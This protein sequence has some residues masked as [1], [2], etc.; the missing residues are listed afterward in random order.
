MGKSPAEIIPTKE[1]SSREIK[2]IIS[3]IS[4][5]DNEAIK[6][7]LD[8]FCKA[9]DSALHSD[10][11][12]RALSPLFSSFEHMTKAYKFTQDQ[13]ANYKKIIARILLDRTDKE[14]TKRRNNFLLASA[15]LALGTLATVFLRSYTDQSA[16][17]KQ[18]MLAE[19]TLKGTF[20]VDPVAARDRF[21]IYSSF[22]CDTMQGLALKTIFDTG[23]ALQ[24]AG[25]IIALTKSCQKNPKTT[26]LRTFLEF[27]STEKKS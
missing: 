22:F 25:S 19:E 6:K 17:C 20:D 1:L 3:Q 16:P 18:K 10:N 24:F 23:A 8:N 15:G 21:E 26:N 9:F 4:A 27:L 12:P 13:E 7:D 5:T 14:D 11:P 2:S